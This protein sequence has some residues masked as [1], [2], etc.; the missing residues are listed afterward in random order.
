MNNVV[1]LEP[2]REHL[3][4]V[5][6][7]GVRLLGSRCTSCSALAFPRRRVCASCRSFDSAED[8]ELASHG[9]LYT[10]A[11][12]RQAPQQFPVPYVIGYVDTDDGVRVFTRIQVDDPSTLRLGARMR[13]DL[14][15]LGAGIDLRSTYT[16]TPA[17]E[18]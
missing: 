4:I 12:V 10:Y 5:T 15:A 16:F 9:T 7:G 11:I 3:F 17:D 18:D 13:A 14:G 6:D 1:A 2:F 8:V